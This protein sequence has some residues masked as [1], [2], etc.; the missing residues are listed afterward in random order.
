VKRP[1]TNGIVER[2]HWTLL[3]EHFRVEGRRTWFETVDEMPTVLDDY[4]VATISAGRTRAAASTAKRPT[5]P[6]SKDCPRHSKGRRP[7]NPESKKPRKPAD[8]AC[9]PRNCQPITL[10]V[11]LDESSG[12][13]HQLR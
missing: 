10:S 7:R 6:S 8:A 12:A 4:L 3:D 13:G 2:L 1:L 11:Q 5:P 9:L